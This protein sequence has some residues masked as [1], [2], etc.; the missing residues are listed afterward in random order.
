MSIPPF[1]P[2]SGPPSDGRPHGAVAGA[3]PQLPRTMS[4]ARRRF[5]AVNGAAF[6]LTALLSGTAGELFTVRPAGGMPLG[7]ALGALQLGVLLLTS[8][9]YDRTLTRHADPLVDLMR[10][11]TRRVHSPPPQPGPAEAATPWPYP[12]Q[13]RQR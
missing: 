3:P 1:S 11:H 10:R 9:Q 8:W 2:G 6:L 12:S 5:L 7:V 13:G 4:G